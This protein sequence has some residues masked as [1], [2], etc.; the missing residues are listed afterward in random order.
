M[1]LTTYMPEFRAKAVELVLA[2]G[3]TLEETAKRIA[4]P[5]GTLAN[6]VA[7]PSAVAIRE[8]QAAI[9]SLSL[10]PRLR[11]CAK[12]WLSSAWRRKCKKSHRV[13]CE[14]VAGRYAFMKS[15]RLD[16]P[17][18]LLCRV[19]D[20]SR[21]GFYAAVECPPSRRAQADE[22]LKVAI[23]AAHVQTRET[24]GPSR[25]Q[26]K[27]VAQ[28]FD[29][30]RDRIVRLRQELGLRCKQRRKFK[31]TTNSRHAFAVAEYLLAVL[32]NGRTIAYAS[33]SS[34]ASPLAW[35]TFHEV[36]KSRP[37]SGATTHRTFL[38]V[39]TK[40]LGAL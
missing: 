39:L 19:F 9:A 37:P 14:G 33:G 13:L 10:K 16:Y 17:L 2:Q 25:L 21:S 40:L 24:Y 20:V 32:L 4:I 6:W 38:T 36:L 18:G 29:T 1:K 23:K 35:P 12:N 7:R 3:L 30:G 27:F 28:G 11:C 22:R 5:K 34:D 31:A 26:P 8:R 15:V